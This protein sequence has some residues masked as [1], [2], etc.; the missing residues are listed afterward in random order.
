MFFLQEPIVLLHMSAYVLEKI[1]IR[2]HFIERNQYATFELEPLLGILVSRQVVHDPKGGRERGVVG[3]IE[4][5]H[6]GG[7]ALE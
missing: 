4:E 1:F 5:S 3:S 7:N 2:S 6:A